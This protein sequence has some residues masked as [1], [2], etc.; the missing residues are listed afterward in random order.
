MYI[1][2]EGDLLGLGVL[3][4]GRLA[5]IEEIS[6]RKLRAPPTWSIAV[7][8]LPMQE[9]VHWEVKMEFLELVKRSETSERA[10]R[11]LRRFL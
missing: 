6:H 11:L 3:I 10:R 7:F 4:V 8:Q 5:A 1:V 2:E 9:L